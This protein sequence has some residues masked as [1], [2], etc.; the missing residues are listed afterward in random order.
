MGVE[1]DALVVFCEV[2]EA[3]REDMVDEQLIVEV[4]VVSVVLVG[5]MRVYLPY[6]L[7]AGNWADFNCE[8]AIAA[9]C[10]LLE[11]S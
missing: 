9:I 3:V 5:T 6:D 11:A 4:D 7:G 10:S 8:C 2:H 1:V